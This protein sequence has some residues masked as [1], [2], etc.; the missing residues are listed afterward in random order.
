MKVLREV[1]FNTIDVGC[2]C[3]CVCVCNINKVVPLH[4]KKGRKYPKHKDRLALLENLT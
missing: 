3:V 4:R 1:Y 2:V